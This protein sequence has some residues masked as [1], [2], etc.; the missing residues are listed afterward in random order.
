MAESP[1]GMVDRVVAVVEV[2]ERSAG[3]LTL[4]QVTARS[5]LPRSS[6]HRILI[7]L[8]QAGWLHRIGYEYTLGLRMFEIGSSLVGRSRLADAARPLMQELATGTGHV[9]HLAVLDDLDVVYLE[10]VGHTYAPGLPARVGGRLPAHCTAV[11]KVLLAH[12]PREIVADYLERGLRRRTPASLVT[13]EALEASLARIREVGYAVDRDEAVTGVVCVGA[14]LFDGGTAV[15]AIAVCGPG[16][17]VRVDEVRHRVMWTAAE[18]S[19][20]GTALTRGEV[21][22]PG[23]RDETGRGR[24]EP[25]TMRS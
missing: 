23:H 2:F 9:T 11:G 15:A 24:V 4:G 18:I 12:A 19:R 13:P 16:R 8:V 20:R 25:A 5:G 17:R 10:K 14:A 7:R 1:V 21:R 6:V 3:M 22:R